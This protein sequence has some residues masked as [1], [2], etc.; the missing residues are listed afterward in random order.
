MYISVPD[1][2]SQTAISQIL[3]TVS[4]PFDDQLNVAFW[5]KTQTNSATVRD[6]SLYNTHFVS[7]AHFLSFR[8]SY[9]M[10]L[11]CI[12]PVSM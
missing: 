2:H 9:G 12:Y 3:R 8:C 1:G 4:Y 11:C 10:H 7:T 6:I 5:Q